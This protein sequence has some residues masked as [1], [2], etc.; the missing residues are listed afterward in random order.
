MAATAGLQR[1][2]TAGS[3]TKATFSL[4]FKRADLGREQNLLSIMV[5][6]GATYLQIMI[7]SDDKLNVSTLNGGADIGV[8]AYNLFRD[9]GA[10]YHFCVGIDTTQSTAADRVKY[11]I[12][13]NQILDADLDN[14][15]YPDEDGV[16]PMNNASDLC[17]IGMWDQGS[18]G[19]GFFAGVM[20]HVHYIDGTQYAAS[21]FGSFDST[22]GIWVPNT[23]PSVTYGTNGFFLKFASGA[24][25][26]DSS[27]EGNN[28]TATGTITQTKDTPEN[29]F[30]TLNSIDNYYAGATFSNGNNT[31]ATV[32]GQYKPSPSTIGLTSGKWY[33]EVKPTAR[34]GGNDYLIG[35]SSTQAVATGDELGDYPDDWAYYSSSGG[36]WNDSSNTSYGD[37][38]DTNDVIGIALDLTNNKLYFAK[39]NTWQNS[40]VPTSGA[41]GTGAISITA[42]SSTPLGAYFAGVSYFA[43]AIATFNTN[44]GNGYFGTTAV[45][46]AEADGNG[47]GQFEY[48]PPTGYFALCT[49]NLGSDS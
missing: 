4:W 6:G 22:S 27:G 48:A 15:N 40:G 39:N 12:N 18:G 5:S 25:G 1:T 44:F 34:A 7:S 10:W 36:Y 20:A 35:I 47:E 43:S 3:N 45:T 21:A 41:T 42:V 11:Y 8:S 24:E 9:V 2:Q 19:S 32:S 13:G 33:W 30:A 29:N 38:Y 23:G 49:N 14:N 17:N 31:V 37:T 26:T 28:L 16:L 46:S